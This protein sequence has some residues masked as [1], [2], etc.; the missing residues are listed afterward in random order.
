M[1]AAQGL[2]IREDPLLRERTSIRL[3]GP[4]IAEILVS[5]TQGLEH[6]PDMATRL[7]GRIEPFGAG[8]NIIAR[9]EALP[10]LLVTRTPVYETCVTGEKEGRVLL[11]ADAALKLPALLAKAASLG[12]G[13]L[14][15]LT[16]IPGSVGGAVAMN[17]GSYGVSFGDL[18][19]SV[20]VFSPVLGLRELA[21]TDVTFSYRSC[22][23][24]NHEGWFLITGVTLAMSKS[25]RNVIRERMREVY[26]GKRA[27]QPVTAR[28]AGCVFKNPA[29]QEPAGR[30]LEQA[31]LKGMSR[32]GMR[33]STVH[34]NFLVNEG[35]GSSEQ[36]LELI[37]LAKDRV[38][39]KSGHRLE[40]EVRL[41]P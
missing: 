7:G 36:A 28:S 25:E 32:G 22:R 10:L 6:L 30:L 18:V 4:A 33:F 27:G 14:E 40:T 5:G 24:H 17:A 13:G 11:K 38:Y 29:P 1:H 20:E 39:Q 37:E 26:A 19:H 8:T 15:G 12:L 2:A 34:A 9:D 16:G 23:L 35:T 21:A 3:G 41:W 31:G